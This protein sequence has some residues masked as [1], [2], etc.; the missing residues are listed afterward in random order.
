MERGMDKLRSM[1]ARRELLLA[2]ILLL[3]GTL[4]RFL[5]LGSFPPGLNQDEASIGF[6]A[7]SLL[8]WGMDRNGDAWPV[9][10]VRTQFSDAQGF[11]P[12]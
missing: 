12:G 11:H 1:L 8:R 3:A 6:D 10:F 7:W 4:L 9:L 2:A 5:C